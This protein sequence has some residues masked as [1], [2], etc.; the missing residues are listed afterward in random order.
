MF[1][2]LMFLV[3]LLL[4]PGLLWARTWTSSSGE[5]TVEADFVEL[6]DGKV[7]LKKN[8]GNTIAV[9]LVKLSKTDKAF[10]AKQ[11]DDQPAVNDDDAGDKKQVKV[12]GGE[13]AIR[14]G[15][16]KTIPLDFAEAPLDEVVEY[17]REAT[18]TEII[19]DEYWLNDIGI[20]A[21]TP[22]TARQ[23]RASLVQALDLVLEPLE[24]TWDVRHEVIFVTSKEASEKNPLLVVYR[25]SSNS[26]VENLIEAITTKVAPNSWDEVG[27]LGSIVDYRGVLVVSQTRQIHAQLAEAFK[28]YVRPEPRGALASVS[29]ELGQKVILDFQDMKL[30]DVRDHLQKKYEVTIELD[31]EA[32]DEVGILMSTPVTFTV[33][34]VSLHS[35]LE[36]ML[37]RIDPSLTWTVNERRLIITTRE[38]A[39]QRL[40]SKVYKVPD[41]AGGELDYLIEV[42]SRTIAPDSWSE[43]GGSGSI[44]NG[45]AAGTLAV[46]QTLQIHLEIDRL[47][48]NLRQLGR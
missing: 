22:V 14:K 32:L 42:V 3:W 15:L 48:R 28:K 34:G 21:D 11:S 10:V 40:I 5:Y 35:A 20:A 18:G 41:L 26:P 31:E 29:R 25:V 4:L 33:T 1:R 23:K 37:M 44:G 39:E 30:E 27:G 9:P 24:L 46:A 17:L 43:V 8:D 36:L 38:A 13:A 6:K 45:P 7:V 47:F 12:Q 19:L 16:A 2:L